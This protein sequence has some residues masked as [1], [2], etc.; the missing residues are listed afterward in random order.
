[1]HPIYFCLEK[2]G[3]AYL[4]SDAFFCKQLVT[5][6]KFNQLKNFTYNSWLKFN[7]IFNKYL[8]LILR[9]LFNAKIFCLLNLTFLRHFLTFPAYGACVQKCPVKCT[10]RLTLLHNYKT[11]YTKISYEKCQVNWMG[12]WMVCLYLSKATCKYFIFLV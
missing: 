2:N 5:L 3:G 12:F 8:L 6:L 4:Y 11:S 9:R 1:M 10:S 7:Y